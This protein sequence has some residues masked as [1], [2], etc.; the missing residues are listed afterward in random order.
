M[1]SRFTELIVDA[2][3]LRG[4]AGF[5]C[6]V[7]G[8]RILEETDSTIERARELPSLSLVSAARSVPLT[9]VAG[10]CVPFSSCC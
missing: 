4:L 8:Y 1:T 2:H 9:S 7:L 6:E 10:R 5:W 3:D